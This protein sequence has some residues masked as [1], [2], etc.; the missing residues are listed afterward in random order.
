MAIEFITKE[1]L[2]GMGASVSVAINGWMAFSRFWLTNK[3]RNEND[4]QHVDML[5]RQE[6][7]IDRLEANNEELRKEV[8]DKEKTIRDYWKTITET[9]A[10]LQ[11]I[12]NSQQLLVEQNE[13]LKNQ[14][15]DLTTSNKN[16][17]SE[18]NQL[19][20]SLGVPR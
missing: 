7:L 3:V 12:E 4:N 5:E 19:R 16:L 10:R 9:Q 2:I 18:I 1:T 15:S 13:S 14:V 11:I 17:I 6:K 8:G 20:T